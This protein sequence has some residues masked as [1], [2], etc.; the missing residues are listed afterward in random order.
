MDVVSV[1]SACAKDKYQKATNR[2]SISE[3]HLNDYLQPLIA[4]VFDQ[5]TKFSFKSTI[6]MA[7]LRA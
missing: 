3:N 6:I 5:M 7:L 1:M 2:N 4:K